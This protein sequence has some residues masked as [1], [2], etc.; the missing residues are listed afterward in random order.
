MARSSKGGGNHNGPG[1]QFSASSKPSV[2]QV[3]S[4]CGKCGSRDWQT[5]KESV[6]S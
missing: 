5:I 1:V 4:Q 6:E 3:Q 2:I